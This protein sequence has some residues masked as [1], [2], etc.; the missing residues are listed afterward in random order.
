MSFK[1]QSDAVLALAAAFRS[2]ES[3]RRPA[4]S[5]AGVTDTYALMQSKSRIQRQSAAVQHAGI[6][7]VLLDCCLH[8]KHKL[9]AQQERERG[10]TRQHLC[11][12]VSTVS[13]LAGEAATASP[14]LAERGGSLD[15][16]SIMRHQLRLASSF[17][18]PS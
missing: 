9:G 7:E 15:G 4:P 13:D 12:K 3:H 2:L 6:N 16:S 8:H 1:I 18:P 14:A 10:I 11:R 5:I 17:C